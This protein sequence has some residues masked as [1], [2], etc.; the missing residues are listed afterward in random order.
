MNALT[1]K[2]KGV[3]R[4]CAWAAWLG[5]A[6]WIATKSPY[7]GPAGFDWAWFA[8]MGLFPKFLLQGDI[9]PIWPESGAEVT[10]D[11]QRQWIYGLLTLA[12]FAWVLVRDSK[13]IDLIAT[14]IA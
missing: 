1:S 7:A 2:K 3:I 6:A 4:A 12:I 11:K 10:P 5:L 8:L 9:P 14:L 13:V